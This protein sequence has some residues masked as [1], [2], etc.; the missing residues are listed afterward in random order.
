MG[1]V[2]MISSIFVIIYIFA[3][4]P[5]QAVDP[6]SDGPYQP[7][8]KTYHGF[9]NNG[10]GKELEVYFP[11]AAGTFPTV[12]FLGGLGGVMP[13]IGYDTV[14]KHVASHGIVVLGMWGLVTN[15]GDN[16]N[17]EWLVDL[18]E[19]VNINLDGRLHGDGAN[20]D[21]HID[22]KNTF[23]WGH[24]AGSHVFVEYLKHHCNTVKGQILFSPVDGFDPFGLVDMFAITPGEY[25]NY[26]TPSLLL[27]TGLDH[28]PG[29][30]LMGD[31]MPSCAPDDLSNMRFF[32]ALPG[33]TWFVNATAYGHG[34]C[35]EDYFY[36][37]LLLTHFCATDKTQDRDIYKA[38]VAGET[39]S[40]IKTILDGDCEYLPFI[41]D[42]TMMPVDATAMKKP[43]VVESS[44]NWECGSPSYCNWQ[45]DPY[46]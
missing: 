2:N 45:P 29:S 10:L 20:V 11:D 14:M 35:L 31:L 9:M 21:F 38:F 46:P 12:Y 17:A 28:T 18:Q 4:L 27:M 6:W 39:V 33:P 25:L 40:F 13:A 32:N 15:P 34:D 16:Y 36:N 5:S 1:I 41:E 26:D 3:V 19:W 22:Q 37:T 30:N 23:L 8:H 42:P 44:M 7:D 43:S 24:S